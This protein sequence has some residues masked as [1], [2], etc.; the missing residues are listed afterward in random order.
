MSVVKYIFVGRAGL[1]SGWGLMLFTAIFAS[2]LWAILYSLGRL[3]P[4]LLNEIN[5]P[6]AGF[7][8]KPS[9]LL[10]LLQVAKIVLLLGVTLIMATI[11]RRSVWSYGL[12]GV[13]PIQNLAV[14]LICGFTA[15]TVIVGLLAALNSIVFGG[16]APYGGSAIIGYAFFWALDFFLSGFYEENL[17]RGYIQHALARGVGFWPAALCT[18]VVFGLTHISNT[19]ETLVGITQVVLAGLIFCSGLRLTGSLWWSIGFHS[20]WNWA[21]SFV[22]GTLNSGIPAVGHWL[23]SHPVGDPRISGGEVGPEGSLVCIALQLV[24]LAS[25]V[26]LLKRKSSYANGRAG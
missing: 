7:L 4:G 18:S 20:A 14:G 15:L 10:A 12:A 6:S 1:R 11:E 2:T 3:A 13:R 17:L 8:S 26:V 22:Y 16:S 24:V 25:M 9:L 23:S 21:Q 19:G 5:N